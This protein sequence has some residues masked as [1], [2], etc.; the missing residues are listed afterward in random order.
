ML[1]AFLGNLPLSGRLHAV[2][3]RAQERGR[4]ALGRRHPDRDHRAVSAHCRRDH[5]KM[6]DKNKK[7]E[8]EPQA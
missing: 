2:R 5:E 4:A 7:A 6:V 1:G 8:P 3:H